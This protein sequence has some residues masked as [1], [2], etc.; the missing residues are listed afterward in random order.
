LA[1]NQ[2]SVFGDRAH[3]LEYMTESI[4]NREF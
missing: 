4:I 2:I 3:P 1:K